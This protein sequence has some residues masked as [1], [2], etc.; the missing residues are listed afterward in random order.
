MITQSQIQQVSD[1]IV[2]WFQP[3]HS[4]SQEKSRLTEPGF[5]SAFSQA[6]R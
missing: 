1:E 4:V 3:E 2:R 5:L 6:M